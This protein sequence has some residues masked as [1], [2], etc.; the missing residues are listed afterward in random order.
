MAI[1]SAAVSSPTEAHATPKLAVTIPSSPLPFVRN[2]RHFDRPSNPLGDPHRIDQLHRGQHYQKFLAA[3]TDRTFRR[4]PEL[5]D[6][7]RSHPLQAEIARTMAI[8]I[9]EPLEMVDVHQD[10]RHH[11]CWLAARR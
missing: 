9:V 3:V 2:R 6:Q 11:L 5:G 1:S 4:R 10:N 7:D 8:S